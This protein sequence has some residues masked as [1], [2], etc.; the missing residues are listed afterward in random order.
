[1]V[2]VQGAM[3][4]LG[5]SRGGVGEEWRRENE[6]A[7]SRLSG[8]VVDTIERERKERGVRPR[9]CHVVRDGVVGPGPD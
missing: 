4:R 2:W 5:R 3:G 9:K 1:V 7:R 8:A 6:W